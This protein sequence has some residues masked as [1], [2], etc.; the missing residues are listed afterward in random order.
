MTDVQR[1]CA[2]CGHSNP[3]DARY[4][5]QC[6]DDS[7]GQLPVAQS[8]L[9]LVIGRAALPVLATAAGLALRVGWRLLQSRWARQAVET[10]VAPAPAA[11]VPARVTAQPVAARRRTIH[12]RS[13]WAVSDGQGGWREGVAEHTIQV[14]D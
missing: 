4:C 7:R 5:A 3:L 1:I 12:I 9:P 14:D 10:R 11:S 2:R 8:N 6:G 13:M